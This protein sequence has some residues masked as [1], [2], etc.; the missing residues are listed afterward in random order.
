MCEGKE[1]LTQTAPLHI[2]YLTNVFLAHQCRFYTY[3]YRKL[4]KAF[5]TLNYSI[6]ANARNQEPFTMTFLTY[7]HSMK[8][9]MTV[10]EKT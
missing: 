5:K 1:G 6:L 3:I 10:F 7:A 9:I 2:M 4:N 8:E